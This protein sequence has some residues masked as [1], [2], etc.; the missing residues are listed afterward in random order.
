MLNLQ[1]RKEF[2]GR[3]LKGT[4]IELANDRHSGATQ[5]ESAKFLEITYPSIDLLAALKAF[6]S[7]S[8]QTIVLMGDRGL[9]KSHLLAA[10]YHSVTDPEATKTW[11]RSWSQQLNNP[12]I[13]QISLRP[14]TRAI[15]VSLHKQNY[16][17]LWDPIFD[18]HPKGERYRGKFEQEG[19][20]V[21]SERLLLEMLQEEPMILLLDEAQTWFDGLTN[22]KQIPRKNWAFNFI[23]ILSEIAKE[24]PDKLT[25][26]ISVRTGQTDIFQQIH[27]LSPKL[28]D[29]KSVESKRDRRRLLLHRLFENRAQIPVQEITNAIEVH[30][31]EYYRLSQLVPSEHE[32][33][34]AE[35]LEAWPFAPHLMQLLEDQILI[36]T[37]AQETRDLIKILA[38]LYKSNVAS[39]AI[40]TA[41]DFNILDD[42]SGITALLDSVSDVHH[43][44][45][46]QKAQ[47][48][49]EAS[50]EA[51]NTRISCPHLHSIINSL[52]LRSLSSGSNRGATRR[53]LQIDITKDKAIDDN[54][55]EAEVSKIVE[56]SF[57]IHPLGD[58]LLFKEEEN[59]ETQLRAEAQ[60]DK[61][62]ESGEDIKR[63][64]GETRYLFAGHGSSSERFHLI[65]PTPSWYYN[66]WNAL[67]EGDR[68]TAW[69]NRL[70]FLALPE[71]PTDIEA[72]L[73]L[74][75]KEQLQKLRNTLIFLLP[76]KDS[77]NIFED[78]NLTRLS[79][80][81][82]LADRYRDKSP[83][84]RPLLE[85][86]QKALRDEL[87]QRYSH[88]AI[89]RKWNFQ[90]HKECQFDI[91]PILVQASQ[92]LESIVEQVKSNLF[93]NEDFS[94]RLQ[95]AAAENLNLATFIKYSQEPS[96]NSLPCIPW[97]GETF[98]KE[99]IGVICAQGQV[100]VNVRGGDLLQTE[101]G[102]SYQNTL[103]RIRSKI[104]GVTGRLLE[105]TLITRP[106]P[107]TKTQL[108]SAKPREENQVPRVNLAVTESITQPLNNPAPFHQNIEHKSSERLFNPSTSPLNLLAAS[109]RWGISADTNC[110]DL[111]IRVES[112]SGAQLLKILKQLPDG[113]TY[114]LSLD[115]ES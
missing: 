13:F 57:N 95:D 76:R 20:D 96:P 26:V 3:V 82:V 52:W 33:V 24:H 62:F 65:P 41:A 54:V 81:V 25:I 107:S 35:F 53:E 27:R 9:G 109:E 36:A 21:P 38:Q 78:R 59:P 98:I 101:P 94:Q 86:F 66:P 17:H 63:I 45:L 49:L 100:A 60:N 105:D 73:G 8:G 87:R 93:V 51:L 110:R 34:R 102:E 84:F 69:D 30:L 113:L 47:R 77:G 92:A 10:L 32:R 4:A 22:S 115:K 61:L 43:A 89:L 46:R 15:A 37:V 5:T 90:D 75:L 106:L 18:N 104:A 68:P 7:N 23:Q 114:E 11:L 55:F 1:L 50:A 39:K 16:R 14:K 2:T 19:T 88:F 74:F 56:T 97:L 91:E 85:K 42:D 112:A 58:R 12:E 108:G 6:G 29:F 71:W 80:M 48:N 40:L 64:S 67:E 103:S 70:R 83:Q 28:V 111:H 72:Q 79:R 31:E 44:T 99:R